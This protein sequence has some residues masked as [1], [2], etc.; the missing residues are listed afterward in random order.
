MKKNIL[1]LLLLVAISALGQEKEAQKKK[2]FFFEPS[3]RIKLIYPMQFGEHSLSEAHNANVGAGWNLSFFNYKNFRFSPGLDWV[4]YDVTDH[5]LVGNFS[6]TNYT[7][8][9]GTISYEVP[10]TSKISVLPDVGLGYVYIS[11]RSSGRYFGAQEGN[12]VRAGMTADF[13]TNRLLTV[14]FSARY[15]HSNLNMAT[16][17]QFQN[18][19]DSADQI[20]LALGL[21]IN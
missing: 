16:N 17:E 11:Q 5:A 21:K 19:Y 10:L 15:I 9:N 1:T 3:G 4:Q 7:S 2:D 6:T 20:Q 8:A 18:Y 13:K 14:F 12:E